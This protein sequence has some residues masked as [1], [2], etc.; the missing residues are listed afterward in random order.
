MKT[1]VVDASLLL[2][3]LLD[4]TPKV[5]EYVSKLLRDAQKQKISLISTP[6]LSLEIGN[7]LRY[8][9]KDRQ[10]ADDVFEKFLKLPIDIIPLSPAQVQKSLRMAY[11]CN[12]SVYNA[13]YHILA[14][15]RNSEFATSDKKYFDSAKHLRKIAYIG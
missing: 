9:L 6:L 2:K 7:G 12:A 15:S 4:D 1:I 5:I 13:S 3:F 11:E 8:S 14:I 10:L